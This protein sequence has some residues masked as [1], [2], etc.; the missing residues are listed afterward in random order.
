VTIAITYFVRGLK[1]EPPLLHSLEQYGDAFVNVLE[2]VRNK[3]ASLSLAVVMPVMH[4]YL[5]D[6][7]GL[8]S[9]L[10]AYDCW[11]G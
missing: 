7:S 10:E 9:L 2:N 4:T 1:L 8:A 5:L 11:W 3:R 6:K